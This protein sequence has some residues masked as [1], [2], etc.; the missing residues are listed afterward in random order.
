MPKLIFDDTSEMFARVSTAYDLPRLQKSRVVVVGCG[1][2]R[3]YIE[4]LARTGIGELVLID[5]DTSS[6]TNVGTQSAT[7][8]EEGVSKVECVRRRVLDINPNMSVVVRQKRFEEIEKSDL[9]YLLIEPWQESFGTP[10]QT[11]LVLSTDNFDAQSFGNRV[12][13]HYGLPSVAAQMY[14]DGTGAELTFTIPGVTPACHR[15]ALAMRYRAYLQEGF[16][17]T[18][19]SHGTPVFC[20]DRINASLGIISL[21][22]L[23]YGG[24]HPRWNQMLEGVGN[25]NLIQLDLL[26]Q[27]PL[28]I[29]N[30]VYSGADQTRTFFDNSVWLPQQQD[31][32]ESNGHAVCP[33]CGG[34][35]DLRN[36]IGSF[37]DD[38][39]QMRG[40]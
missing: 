15:C 23:H 12:A 37:N 26:P 20:A 28:A 21:M 6:L 3:G 35:G 40:A 10:I 31:H 1:G 4:S 8:S 17:N 2:S 38:L 27:T 24:S 33:D 7:F 30:R 13:L 18:T 19:T 32:P 39:Y 25:R 11:M 16:K 5:P 9:E 29:F 22:V 14:Q 34:S 36:A